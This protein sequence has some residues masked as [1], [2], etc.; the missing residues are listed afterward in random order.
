MTTPAAPTPPDLLDVW[1]MAGLVVRQGDLE[2]RYLDDELVHELALLAAQGIHDPGFMPFTFPWSVGEPTAVARS[3]LAYQWGARSRLSPESWTMELAIVRGGRVLGVQ[4]I[5]ATDF[6]VRRE[7][8]T[9]S[10]LGRAHQGQGI[11]TRTRLMMLGLGFDGLGALGMTTA[12]W[13]DNASSLS[14]TR[15]VGY[16]ENGRGWLERGGERTAE[17]RFRLERGDW[18]AGLPTLDALVAQ[19]GPIELEGVERVRAFLGL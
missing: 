13:V 2:L 18:E 11:G 16:R 9:G 5:F 14:V 19:H 17:Q 10:W 7:A 6:V 15:K 3:V 8:E 12:A 4:S 1:P